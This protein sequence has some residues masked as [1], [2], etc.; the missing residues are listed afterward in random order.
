MERLAF[1]AVGNLHNSNLLFDMKQSIIVLC[2]HHNG[3]QY[4]E[5]GRVGL[6]RRTNVFQ[7]SRAYRCEHIPV[8]HGV[9]KLEKYGNIRI[10]KTSSTMVEGQS[11][12]V[13]SVAAFIISPD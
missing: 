9:T 3:S 11:D 1:C 6:G 12:F 2:Q 8:G 7:Q 4:L 13:I 10:G 5:Y